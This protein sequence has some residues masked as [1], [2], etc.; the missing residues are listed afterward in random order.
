MRTRSGESGRRNCGKASES[1]T[2]RTARPWVGWLFPITG[3]AALLWFL[4]R[5]LPKPSRAVY[6]CQRVAAPVASSFVTYVLGL[7][8]TFVVLRK[9][10]ERIYQ[11]RH[12]IAA[13]CVAVGLVTAFFTISTIGTRAGAAAEALW[14][15][16]DLPN[17][18]MGVA[19][20]VHPGRVAWVY[21]PDAA[22]WDG[23][24]NYWW[25]DTYTDPEVVRSMMSR[26]IRWLA[27]EADEAAA[28]DAIFR[29][30]NE[31]HGYG[32]IGYQP[33]E[34]IAVKINLI[35]SYD[36]DWDSNLVNPSPQMVEALLRQLVD[37]AGVDESGIT[38][39]DGLW[40]VS[41]QIYDRCHALYPGVRFAENAGYGGGGGRITVS[42]DSNVKLH[43]GDPTVIDSG[44]VC[45]AD[46]VVE[47]DYFIN[48]ALFKPH[49]L[50]GMTLCAKNNFGSVWRPHARTGAPW[51]GWDPDNM[52]ETVAAFDWSSPGYQEWPGRPM[53]SFNPLVDL[54]GHENLGGKTLLYLIDGLYATPVHQGGEPAKWLSAPFDNDWTSSL[55]ASQDGVAIDSVALDFLRSEPTKTANVRGSI[56]NYLHEA[57]RAHDPPSGTWY[58]PEGD[59]TRLESLGT[60]EHW[61]NAIDKKYT[62]NLGS[63]DG[64]ELISAGA[65]F[66]PGMTV[67]ADYDGAH[68][69]HGADVDG[70]GDADMIGAAVNADDVAWWENTEGD[71]STWTRHS[72]DDDF[73]GA[74][75]VYAADLDDDQDIDI[76][77]AAVYA[78]EIAWWENVDGDGLTW[79]KHTVDGDFDLAGGVYAEDVDGDGDL[80]V[81]GAA[82]YDD[83]ITWWENK[84]GEA[85]D[86]KDRWTEHAVDEDFDF[87]WCVYAVDLD[88]DEDMDILG[89]AH[90]INGVG[91]DEIAW[92]ENMDGVGTTWMKHTV[93]GDFWEALCVYAED[94]DGDG[95]MDVLG[96]AVAADDITWWE[97]RGG[98]AGDWKDNWT[99][100]T[101]AGNADGAVW[102]YA[103]DMDADG[104]IDVLGAAYY[105]NDMIWWENMRG[106]GKTW[107]EHVI[108]GDYANAHGI[109]ATDVDGD[110]DPDVL[111][112]SVGLSD[113]TWWENAI[114]IAVVCKPPT[115]TSHPG[116]QARNVGLTASF[117]VTALGTRLEYQWQVS[118]D[119]GGGFH[120]VATGGT[121]RTSASY[122][123]EALTLADHGHQYRCVVRND[124]GQETSMPVTLTV[125]AQADFDQDGDV[126][127]ADFGH[128]Q[129]CLA[130]PGNIRE[131]EC[132]DADLDHD[133]D[134]DRAD[135]SK[136]QSQ[137]TGATPRR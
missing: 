37:N 56:D 45:F 70:D 124:C 123:T 61:N 87:A 74:L 21:D 108:D 36:R 101:I 44:D 119:D 132:A 18:P 58:D 115:I 57:A 22:N 55:F 78:D 103:M 40:Y 107:R 59:G 114:A 122:T 125:W 111:G 53:G 13:L 137:T 23:S 128:L 20:G 17:T 2:A 80:D 25:S 54:M 79:A 30:F 66:L 27:G 42:H 94:L 86:W 97:N 88:G 49:V 99:E 81:L 19:R 46:F 32:D 24:S 93:D 52:H 60:H 28:W 47:A 72:V 5:V 112:A 75:T 16:T 41:D 113:I 95:D 130:L 118:T 10:K 35:Q 9:A 71:G 29:N 91:S 89:A 117:R 12:L 121:G 129:R 38:I 84:K 26:A 120:D 8:A 48:L 69:V 31:A 126:D 63:G 7:L 135:V 85:E 34:K 6:P 67:E 90:S 131:P 64:I 92:W 133:E 68:S 109:H 15:P 100:H 39:Y 73:D 104:D 96:A 62:G 3:L 105:A 116:S 14:V 77:A 11:S 110:G 33:G 106:D 134:I 98:E 76:L 136:L 83:D 50:A 82:G 51:S 1:L 43:Y 102:V 4:V 65:S 127:Q